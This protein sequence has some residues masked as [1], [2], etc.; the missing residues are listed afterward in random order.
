MKRTIYLK[1]K[2]VIYRQDAGEAIIFNP[3]NSDIVILNSTGCFIWSLIDGKNGTK[4]MVNKV[5]DE[6]DVE[7]SRAE[8]DTE[9]F[10]DQLERKGFVKKSKFHEA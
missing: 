2:D 3:E 6:F 5:I 8:K 7:V 4:G 9:A 10:L 1:N